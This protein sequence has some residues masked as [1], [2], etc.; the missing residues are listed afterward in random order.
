[1]STI[2]SPLLRY[3]D[4]RYKL[5]LSDETKRI[6]RG[7]LSH[8]FLLQDQSRSYFLKQYGIRDPKRLAQIHEVKLFFYQQGIPVILPLYDAAGATFFEFGQLWYALFPFIEARFLEAPLSFAA[9]QAAGTMLAHI[10]Q[11]GRSKKRPLV[12]LTAEGWNKQDFIVHAERLIHLIEQQKTSNTFDQQVLSHLKWRI[13]IVS[14]LGDRYEQ[15]GLQNDHLIH[16]DYHEKN[17]FFNAQDQVTEVYDFEK[18]KLSPRILEVGRS[19]NLITLSQSL[20]AAA[21]AKA[22]MYLQSYIEQY[23]L[24]KDEVA[25]MIDLYYHKRLHDLWIE[26]EH[27]LNANT[28][29]DDIL[30]GFYYVIRYYAKHLD[31]IRKE[32]MK[33][34]R[35]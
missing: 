14:A 5:R 7:Y 29:L 22:K 30:D 11:A 19:M 24:S 6:G 10:H 34:L 12:Q 18:T 26:E 31:Q 4:S 16:G 9:L 25:N 32:I 13:P 3:I 17:L 27:Y 23:P 28:R 35:F 20:D 2:S 33:D 21:I 15:H 8:N 1:M